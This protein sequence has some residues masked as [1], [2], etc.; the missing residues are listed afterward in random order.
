VISS[1][2]K[3]DYQ[4]GY[5]VV[6]RENAVKIHISEIELLMIESTA[7]S[8]TAALLSELTK[9]KVKVI[10]CDEKRNPSSELVPY[11][12]C[13]DTSAKI[14]EQIKWDDFNKKTIWTE[15]VSEKIRNQARLLKENG[16]KEAALLDSYINEIEFGDKTN[17]EGHA[18]KVYFDALFGKQF[19][20]T[21]DNSIN[22]SLNYGYGVI[23]SE[24]NREIVS[25]GYITQ[26]G[27]FH[28]N[29]FNQFNLGSDLMEPFRPVIDRKVVNMM[30]QKFEHDEKMEMLKVLQSEVYI[31]DRK[32]LV[33][34]AIKIYVK[35]VFDALSDHDVSEIKFYRNEL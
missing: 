15:V 2:A 26:L 22:A 9:K 23:L 28:D 10:F 34:N 3:L 14:R 5:L 21:E 16:K 19:T 6:R 33:S 24:F 18:A 27:L 25:N 30:P 7:V 12:G 13:H 31:A 29:V 32:E 20:R 1:N 4:M 17:R 8:L 35:S 11:Y